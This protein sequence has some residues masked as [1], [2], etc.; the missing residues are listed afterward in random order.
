MPRLTTL[1]KAELLALPVVTTLGWFVPLPP[2][3]TLGLGALVTAGSLLL[4]LQGFCRD[5]WLWLA[6][7]RATVKPE[8]H[9][10]QCLCVE[11]ALGLTGILAAAGLTAFRLGPPVPVTQAGLTLGVALVLAVGFALKDFVFEWSPWKIYR[12]RDHAALHFRWTR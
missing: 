9:H 12:A 1:E 8:P 5:L 10:A 6:A 2:G 3:F 7:R 11:S 4:L